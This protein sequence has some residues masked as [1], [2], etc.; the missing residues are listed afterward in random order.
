M[1]VLVAVKSE[2]VDLVDGIC[3]YDCIARSEFVREKGFG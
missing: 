3:R 1:I 2:D